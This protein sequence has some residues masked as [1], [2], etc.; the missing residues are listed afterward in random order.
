MNG[1]RF[2]LRRDV[3]K[4][5]PPRPAPHPRSTRPEPFRADDRAAPDFW[6]GE[7]R[8]HA[9]RAVPP[10]AVDRGRAP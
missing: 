7:E 9:P 3:Q 4:H 5:P 10:P 6:R 1:Q 8:R 2:T